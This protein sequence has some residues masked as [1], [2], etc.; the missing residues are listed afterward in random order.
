MKTELAYSEAK[1]YSVAAQMTKMKVLSKFTSIED[2]LRVDNGWKPW[3]LL[4][5][6]FSHLSKVQDT[7]LNYDLKS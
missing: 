1:V 7:I 3:Y 2:S 6:I 5:L 4:L